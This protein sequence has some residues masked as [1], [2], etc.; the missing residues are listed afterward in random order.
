[1]SHHPLPLPP[2]P[3]HDSPQHQPPAVTAIAAAS[4]LSQKNKRKK[5]KPTGPARAESSTSNTS[6]DTLKSLCPVPGCKEKIGIMSILCE[7]C[8]TKYCMA[9]RLPESHS[10][11]CT[12]RAR[13]QTAA[14]FRQESMHFITQQQRDPVATNAR[15][16]SV[17][18]SKE[19]LRHRLR[20]K[21]KDARGGQT[22][23]GGKKA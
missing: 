4:P 13:A 10:P 1:M 18:K 2:D 20:E 16:F 9:H 8:N 7:W 6:V 17:E 15:T 12:D 23:R 5:K 21:I 22:Q 14:S 19:E 11:K 3:S